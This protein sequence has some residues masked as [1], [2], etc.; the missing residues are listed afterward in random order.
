MTS[1]TRAKDD[2]VMANRSGLENQLSSLREQLAEAWWNEEPLDKIQ[3][4]ENE[5]EAYK[6][7]LQ[8]GQ[9]GHAEKV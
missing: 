2:T 3:Q 9:T 6:R 5:I 7:Q 4:I 8:P 1:S